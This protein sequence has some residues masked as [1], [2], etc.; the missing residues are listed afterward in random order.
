VSRSLPGIAILDD[1]Q[2]A[3]LRFADWSVLSG[4]AEIKVFTAHMGQIDELA[5]RLASYEI[6][7]L[8]R[9]RTAFSREVLGRLPNL[10][11]IVTTGMWNAAIDLDAAATLGIMV[12]GTGA[13]LEPTVELTWALIL[14]AL[15]N[16]PAELAAVRDGGWQITVGEDLYGR[17]LG[18]VGLGNIGRAVASIATAFGM[19][20]IAWSPNMTSDIA[21]KSGATR[22]DKESLFRD[23]DV[24]TIHLKLSER[25]R[26]IVGAAELGLMK[27]EAILI[28]TS[29]GPLVDQTA[30]MAALAG[31]QIARAAVDVYDEEPL[32]INHPL[33][34]F[35]NL[36]A[37]PHIGYV[38]RRMYE[39]FFADTVE[40]IVSWLDGHPVR[41]M[42]GSRVSR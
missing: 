6:I 39:V 20:I 32:P 2:S 25:S 33:R 12:C 29:R 9:E 8:M 28:N 36:I 15:R 7:C 3:A 17:T 13:T 11:L 31:G 10:K 42:N 40:N 37:T 30:L 26:G 19:K 14:S 1:Y 35:K 22:V 4:R 24:V 27:R 38:S 18:I 21:A 23:S 16:I 41:V 5:R 34:N